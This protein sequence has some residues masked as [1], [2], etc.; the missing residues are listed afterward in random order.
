[1]KKEFKVMRCEKSIGPNNIVG[2][3]EDKQYQDYITV[4]T[5]LKKL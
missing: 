5:K 2:G 3:G 1:M 4:L